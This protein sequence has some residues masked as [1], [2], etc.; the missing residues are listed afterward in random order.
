MR[1]KIAKAMRRGVDAAG[2]TRQDYRR[3]KRAW[4]RIPRPQRANLFS[5]SRPWIGHADTSGAIKT[6]G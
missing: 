3:L 5:R 1:G 2:G 6:G 4:N